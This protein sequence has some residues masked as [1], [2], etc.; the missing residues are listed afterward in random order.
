MREV[1]RASATR[2][3]LRDATQSHLRSLVGRPES[4]KW[5]GLTPFDCRARRQ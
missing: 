1:R 4:C 3:E 2:G 5:C